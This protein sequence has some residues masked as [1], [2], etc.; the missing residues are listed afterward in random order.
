MKLLKKQRIKIKLIPPFFLKMFTKERNIQERIKQANALHTIE[1][2]NT[3]KQILS[4]DKNLESII[5]NYCLTLNEPINYDFTAEEKKRILEHFCYVFL[6][7]KLPAHKIT[8]MLAKI[9]ETY[10]L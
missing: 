4:T 8:K 9:Q 10:D 7:L 1:L 6:T 5:F 3:L 2:D